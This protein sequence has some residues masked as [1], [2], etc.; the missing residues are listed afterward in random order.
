MDLLQEFGAPSE[1]CIDLHDVQDARRLRYT[2]LFRNRPAPLI[3]YVVEV[4]VQALL[5][6]V[7]QTRFR[8]EP[9]SIQALQ[10]VLAMRGEPAWLGVLKPG[11]LDIYAT[12]LQPAENT[13]P[14]WFSSDS[15]EATSILPR[16]AQGEEITPAADLRL[17]DVLFGLMSDAGEALRQRGVSTD[18]TIALIGRALFLRYLIGRKIVLSE[19]LPSIS[20]SAAS[21]TT[22]MDNAATLAETNHWLDN[23]FNGD[24]LALP[25]TDYTEYFHLLVQHHGPAVTQPLSAI[26]TL[27]KPVAPGVSQRRLD[28]GDLDFDHLPI[29]LLSE[30]YEDLIHR[31][32][33]SGRHSTSVYYTPYHIAEYMVEEAFYANPI[34]SAAR[35]LDPAC[36]AGIFLVAG[37]RKL[38][39][40]RFSETGKQPSRQ[41]IRDIL[42]QQLVGFDINGH[43]R[44]LAALAL[45][46]TALE[47][48]PHPAPVEALRFNK[49]ENS[50]L[51]D[52]ADLSSSP[53]ELVPMVGSLGTHVLNRYRN[54]FDIVIGNP[55]WTS[56]TKKDAAID[57]LFTQRC[58]EVAAQRGL[59]EIARDYHNP[60]RVPDLPF[61]W[62][63][64]AWAKP[65]GRIALAL[66]GRWLFKQSPAGVAAR[67]A[68]FCALKVTGI[69]N[70]AALRHTRVWPGMDQPFCLLFADNELPQ[71]GDQ[72]IFVSPHH[73]PTLNDKGLLRIDASDANPVA[74][75]LVLD[76]PAALKTLYRGTAL[77]LAI[78]NKIRRRW[79]YTI[80]HYWEKNAGLYSGQGFQVASR[81]QDD[82]FLTGKPELQADYDLHPFVVLDQALDTYIPRGLHRT[83]APEIYKAPLLLVRKTLRE[84]RSRGRALSSASDLAF[85]ESY[86]GYSTSGHP[87]AEYL[88]NYLLVLLHSKFFEYITL[89]T[90]GQFGVEREVQQILDINRFPFIPPE[91]LLPEQ[92][93]DIEAA[94]KQLIDNQP[95]WPFLDDIVAKVYGLSPID[96]QVMT[97]TLAINAPY[98]SARDRGLTQVSEEHAQ[99]FITSLEK[100]L[101]AILGV[102]GR[103]VQVQALPA[104]SQALPWRFFS[105]AVDVAQPA[106]ELPSHWIKHVSDLGISRITIL[107]ADQPRLTVGLLNRYR[108]WTQSEAR[109]LASEL[110]W[111]FG[112]RLEELSPQCED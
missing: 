108:Y 46:L 19:H 51:I 3:D 53:N 27:D 44:T 92:R 24:L 50:V 72:F 76:N 54:A 13:T 97:D 110:I 83:R 94:A 96:Q 47:L 12:D 109:L 1:S 82:S 31:F 49:L 56:L 71:S 14:V 101:A 11:R 84:D 62:G 106:L 111:E 65:S 63:A 9:L 57:Q 21:L 77:D 86:F 43:A 6:V 17:R 80:G 81:S 5:Y 40:L 4:Q 85:N 103:K 29:G 35:L 102:G 22:C 20:P 95:D 26:M 107:S 8:Q 28:W 16:L 98:A 38:V 89:M 104:T 69:L 59:D 18:E 2:D 42:H 70:G 68:L 30:T 32:D 64:M 78:V 10:R 34:G 99:A 52:V 112:V 61:V 37:L 55:P 79:E 75:D 48:D 105:I 33:K 23:T 36:G 88:I 58:R 41:Q 87:Y 15:L 90:S 25:T 74:F 67:K 100:E 39:E 7:D 45:Y 60:D 91:E 73:E 93:N 66:A